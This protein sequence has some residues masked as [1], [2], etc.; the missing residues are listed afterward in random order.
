MARARSA[1]AAASAAAGAA[2]TVL[3][4]AVGAAGAAGAAG[5]AGAAAAGAARWL[6]WRLRFATASAATATA[7]ATTPEATTTTPGRIPIAKLRRECGPLTL[8]G[9]AREQGRRAQRRPGGTSG[10]QARL[11]R[12]TSA[13]PVAT[14]AQMQPSSS[15]SSSSAASVV[16]PPPPPPP[17]S[18][19]GVRLYELECLAAGWRRRACERRAAAADWQVPAEPTCAG[20]ACCPLE[21]PPARSRSGTSAHAALCGQCVA[22]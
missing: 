12:R 2:G 1:G 16:P 18:S 8:A 15:S 19:V 11:S 14:S 3:G 21:P 20:S 13:A 5:P 7:T 10:R 6:A 9:R 4:A 17:P 22:C